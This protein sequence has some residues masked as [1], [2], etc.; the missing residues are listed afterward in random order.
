MKRSTQ[1]E[2]EYERYGDTQYCAY[3]PALAIAGEYNLKFIVNV[4]KDPKSL[5]YDHFKEL[6]R[7]IGVDLKEDK[8]KAEISRR[9]NADMSIVE[10]SGVNGLSKLYIYEHSG[11]SALVGFLDPQLDN[12]LRPRT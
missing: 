10:G 9:L 3:D 11:S 7:W 2:S 4:A 6:G 12:F 5:E 1:L 8:I